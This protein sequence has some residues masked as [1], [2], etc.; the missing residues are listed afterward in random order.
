MLQSLLIE[1]RKCYGY[2]QVSTKKQLED[3]VS[4]EE[5]KTRIVRYCE[6]NS[7]ELIEISINQTISE[8]ETRKTEPAQL[9]ELVE[10]MSVGST[11]IVTDIARL[12][13][14]VRE[15]LRIAK[16]LELKN[17]KLIIINQ[18]LDTGTSLG[19][20]GSQ[21][22]VEFA[23]LGSRITTSRIAS[24]NQAKR[25]TGEFIGRIPYGWRNSGGKRS[26]VV[27][28]PEE[29]A[30]LKLIYE[31]AAEVDSHRQRLRTD[32]WIAKQLNE[33]KVAPP[34]RSKTWH[35]RNITLILNRKSGPAMKP[36]EVSTD[37]RDY[38]PLRDRNLPILPPPELIYHN[39]EEFIRDLETRTV[40]LDPGSSDDE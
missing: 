35:N 18:G 29:Q 6:Q 3:G 2:I 19:K 28:V 1:T 24:L 40:D 39:I 30:V 4:V 32:Y 37:P 34:G 15:F 10:R 38:V 27:E 13:K 17:C 14:S 25:D 5:Q 26:L 22:R 20:L 12:A 23:E 16:S 7:F 9:Q 8:P 11:L 36:I 33:L 31:W 21:I